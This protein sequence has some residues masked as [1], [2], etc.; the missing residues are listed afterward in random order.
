MRQSC[1][2]VFK[3]DPQSYIARWQLSFVLG[4]YDA[5]WH[6]FRLVFGVSSHGGFGIMSFIVIY[7]YAIWEEYLFILGLG[8]V[9]GF[10]TH[11]EG[12]EDI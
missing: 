4:G 5:L 9:R 3:G 1:L 10:A 11:E 12:W 7:F 8:R 2:Y 6:R